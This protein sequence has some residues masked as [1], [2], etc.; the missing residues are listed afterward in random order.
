MVFQ[1]PVG[2]ERFAV[3]ALEIPYSRLQLAIKYLAWV[4]FDRTVY[5]L[6]RAVE[7]IVSNPGGGSQRMCCSFLD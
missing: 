1:P 2:C 3:L 5:I 4:K 6:G 7:I